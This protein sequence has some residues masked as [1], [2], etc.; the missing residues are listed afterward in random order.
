MNRTPMA[1]QDITVGV[2]HRKHDTWNM[3]TC[4]YI[5][6]NF[7]PM[8]HIKVKKDHTPMMQTYKFRFSLSHED[9]CALI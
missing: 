9:N 2:V 3:I 5:K 4:F 8:T 1:V 6:V 7:N